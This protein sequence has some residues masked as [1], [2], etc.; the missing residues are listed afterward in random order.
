MG[1]P[2]VPVLLGLAAVLLPA[3]TALPDV[4]VTPGRPPTTFQA[5]PSVAVLGD[6][7]VVGFNDKGFLDPRDSF[8]RARAGYAVSFDRG[9]T[10]TYASELPLAGEG[11]ETGGDPGLIACG[12]AFY[13]SYLYFH[14]QFG[15]TIG[16]S[17]GTASGGT[18]V[19]GL[20]RP[21]GIADDGLFDKPYLACDPARSVL[22]V[23]YTRFIGGLNEGSRTQVEVVWSTDASQTWSA[24]TRLGKAVQEPKAAIGAIPAVGADGTLTVL[25][26]HRRTPHVK[27]CFLASST[28]GGASFGRTRRI[29][30]CKAR[31][32]PATR[33]Q[34]PHLAADPRIAGRLYVA[35][36][37]GDR[38]LGD[39]F[40]ARSTDGGRRFRR[41]R[42]TR[43]ARGSA[44]F[45]PWLTVDPNDGEVGLIWYDRRLPPRNRA[46]D[47]FFARSVDG[48]RFGD[49]ARLTTVSTDR[50]PS[51]M[52]TQFDDYIGLTADGSGYHAVWTDDR[53][54]SENITVYYGYVPK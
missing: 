1:N 18:L 37:A 6:V 51:G 9:D 4:P 32:P 29:R 45:F 46:L 50:G 3:Q 13:Y 38:G 25:W 42:V 19:W 24:P 44:Q 52:L 23:V 8:A 20:P 48:L 14:P 31:Q 40:V 11:D 36:A 5:E 7:V 41:R 33:G 30:G 49:P 21:V 39:I 16:V 10:W 47:V 22:Y 43:D 17:R 54:T 12:G 2:M 34:F 35:W 15:L 26:T 28:D 27:R 53:I